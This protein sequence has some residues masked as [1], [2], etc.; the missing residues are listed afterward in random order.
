M[1]VLGGTAQEIL[2]LL[3]NRPDLLALSAEHGTAVPARDDNGITAE[4]AA[5]IQ[6][7]KEKAAGD[8]NL[9]EIVRMAIKAI[10]KKSGEYTFE[11]ARRFLELTGGAA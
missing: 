3:N 9:A 10:G 6:A 1:I 5:Q 2:E 4:Q 8:G 11:D 7:V